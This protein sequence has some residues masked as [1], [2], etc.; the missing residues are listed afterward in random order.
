MNVAAFHLAHPVVQHLIRA[1]DLRAVE[2]FLPDHLRGI[3][4]THT[5]LSLTAILVSR[6]MIN[7]HEANRALAHQSSDLSTM[8]IMSLNV[9]QPHSS[10]PEDREDWEIACNM[11]LPNSEPEIDSENG[12]SVF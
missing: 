7:L 5:N 6:F 9:A 4:L 1:Q 11:I 12:V 8:Q 3:V 10:E 2:C